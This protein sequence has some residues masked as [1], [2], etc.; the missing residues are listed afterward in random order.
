M[1]LSSMPCGKLSKLIYHTCD[2]ITPPLS[3][4]EKRWTP[5]LTISHNHFER[6][7][8][9]RKGK[10]KSMELPHH[11]MIN[12][13][14]WPLLTLRFLVSGRHGNSVV[15]HVNESGGPSDLVCDAKCRVVPSDGC[16]TIWCELMKNGVGSNAN[17]CIYYELV[18]ILTFFL[19]PVLPFFFLF[20]LHLCSFPPLGVLLAFIY[21]VSSD[22]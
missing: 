15:W 1:W 19:P 17:I 7:K 4:L 13:I 8:Q 14:V 12:K 3:A 2:T 22:F 20:S 16:K 6:G 5:S 9:R 10:R 21:F 11:L 18:E